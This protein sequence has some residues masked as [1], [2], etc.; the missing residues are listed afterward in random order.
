[1]IDENASRILIVETGSVLDEAIKN[2]VT[3]EPELQVAVL[4]YNDD[5]A[6]I[7]KEI[8]K[9]FPD[10]IVLSE[11]KPVDRNLTLEILRSVLA[12]RV[13]LIIARLDDNILEVY[14]KQSIRTTRNEDLLALLKHR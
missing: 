9:A 4:A 1:M 13:R 14:D 7:I 3:D 11:V 8:L 2:A 10:V 12:D 5:P 6:T